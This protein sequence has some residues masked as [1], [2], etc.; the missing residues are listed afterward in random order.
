MKNAGD[1]GL[2]NLVEGGD[3]ILRKLF[4]I[5]LL[6]GNIASGIGDRVCVPRVWGC[7]AC[8]REPHEKSDRG[9]A[10]RVLA[11]RLLSRGL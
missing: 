7:E 8:F 3:V 10:P 6:Q 2:Q 1:K 4:S 11:R 9:C 5:L